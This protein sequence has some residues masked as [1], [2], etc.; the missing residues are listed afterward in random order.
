[1][2]NRKA[3]F[4]TTILRKR[5]SMSNWGIEAPRVSQ[6]AGC[7]HQIGIFSELENPTIRSEGVLLQ[8]R[9]EPLHDSGPATVGVKINTRLPIQRHRVLSVLQLSSHAQSP[10]CFTVQEG[11]SSCPG[12]QCRLVGCNTNPY[13]YEL[14]STERNNAS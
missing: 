9:T 10:R 5:M 14:P 13:D 12:Q 11:S 3:T 7:L 1:M 2:R 6:Q 8:S 4:A